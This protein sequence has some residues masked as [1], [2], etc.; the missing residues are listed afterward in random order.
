MSVTTVMM[1]ASLN[2]AATSDA[3]R[4]LSPR[5]W[6][7][8]GL[9][10]GLGLR[11]GFGFG[12]G[13]GFGLARRFSAEKPRSLYLLTSPYISLHLPTSRYIWRR[14]SAEKPRSR[15]RPVR[16]LSPSGDVGRYRGKKYM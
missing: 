6:L 15:V 11:L 5:S 12:F 8:L 3:R 4:T 9:G 7:A 2:S 16:R 13:F 1:P 10:L 14:S